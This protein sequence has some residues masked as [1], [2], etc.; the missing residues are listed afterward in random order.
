MAVPSSRRKPSRQQVADDAADPDRAAVEA[1]EVDEVRVG[2]RRRGA[3]RRRGRA[4]AG[5]RGRARSAGVAGSRDA[6]RRRPPGRAAASP[7]TRRSLRPRGRTAYRRSFAVG[8]GRRTMPATVARWPSS[9][10][11]TGIP[12]PG[13]TEHDHPLLPDDE[14]RAPAVAELVDRRRS[15][16]GRSRAAIPGAIAGRAY[17]S[18]GA[19]TGRRAQRVRCASPRAAARRTTCRPC[20][21]MRTRDPTAGAVACRWRTDLDRAGRRPGRRRACRCRR[22]AIAGA[23]TTATIATDRPLVRFA[24]AIE[25]GRTAGALADPDAVGLG[26]GDAVADGVGVGAGATM[27]TSAASRRQRR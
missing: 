18:I 17:R 15:G 11:A 23:V 26:V 20:P 5:G 6:R 21:S 7:S 12:A 24:A 1:R 13:L 22:A 9:T 14:L 16:R 4:L 3:G 2:D 27:A 25:I 10:D 8:Y 19:G